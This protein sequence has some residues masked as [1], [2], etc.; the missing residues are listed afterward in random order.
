MLIVVAVVGI[1]ALMA[2]PALQDSA[3]KRQVK[4]GLALAD[5]A[6]KGVELAYALAGDM[7]AD[8]KAAGIPEHGKIVGTYVKDVNVEGGAITLTFGNNASKALE[9]KKLTLRPAVVPG[10]PLGADRLALPQHRDAEEHG[11]ARQGRHRHPAELAAGRVP[12]GGGEVTPEY[13]DEAKPHL[14]K[15]DTVLRKL[16]KKYPD[17]D[18]GTRGDAFQ[19]LARSIVGQQISVKAAQS[20]WNRFAEARGKGQREERGRR[21]RPRRSARAASRAARSPT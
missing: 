13:W 20:I 2:I 4:E 1:L 5:V 9:G 14:S 17:A 6:K 3:L 12:R 8:N 21:S 7:P 15:R 10:E 19:T 16:I 18:L 11:G